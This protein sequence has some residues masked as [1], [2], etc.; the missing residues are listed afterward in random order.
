MT[1]FRGLLRLLALLLAFALIASACGGDDDSDADAATDQTATDDDGDAGDDGAAAADDG[2][3]DDGAADDGAEGPTLTIALEADMAPTGFD[4]LRYAQAQFV[5]HSTLY[6][7]LFVTDTEGEVVPS[8]VTDFVYNDDS[9]QLTLT[10]RE[11][12]TFADGTPLD[13]ELVKANLDRRGESTLQGYALFREG[14]EAEIADVEATDTYVVTITFAAEQPEGHLLLAD[15]SGVIV[16]PGGVADATTLEA[17][18]EGS[19]VYELVA[20]ETTRGSTFT[21]RKKG[22]HPDSDAWA[23]DTIVFDI[24]TDDQARANAVISGQADIATSIQAGQLDLVE[25]E[26]GLAQIGGQITSWNVLDKL[27]ITAP[28]F[29]FVETRLALSLALDREAIVEALAPGARATVQPF[30]VG[31]PGHDPSIDERY[32]FD[33]ER[34]RELLESVGLGD[35]FE[36]DKWVL[37]APNE[38][39]LISAAMWEEHLNVKM[40]FIT[41]ASTEEIF[42]S[43]RIQPMITNTWGLGNSPAGFIAGPVTGGFMN[44][45][46]ASDPEIE[47][48]LGPALGGDE[49]ALTDLNNALVDRGWWFSLWEDFN[50]AGYNPETISEVPFA[51]LAGFLVTA[52]VQPAG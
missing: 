1:G 46:E 13:A 16:G 3:G 23:Y 19:G 52:A 22:D 38:V 39:E 43:V 20:D 31:A 42:A 5:F 11:D 44:Y 4:A 15:T 37:P 51:G 21:V 9:T 45:Q 10:L 27:G 30:P 17:A 12:I 28:E 6:D 8:L 18:P 7:A 40:N 24:I 36:F 33:P 47:A 41:A 29:E 34:A 50:Y 14:E 32:A 35:G 48:A 26:A 49:Q 25:S 2:G